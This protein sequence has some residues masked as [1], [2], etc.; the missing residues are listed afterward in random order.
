MFLAFSAACLITPQALFSDAAL[1]QAIDAR[2]MEADRLLKQGNEQLT[3]NQPEAALPTLQAALKLYRDLKDRAAEEQTLKSVGNAYQAL[4]QYEQAISHQQQALEIA[5]EIKDRNL[6]ARALH[7]IGLAYEGLKESA[8]AIEYYGQSLTVSQSSQNVEMEN[9]TLVNLGFLYKSLRDFPKANDYFKRRLELAEKAQ[10]STDRADSLYYICG[11]YL[12][13]GDF[14]NSIQTCQQA[15]T[16]YRDLKNQRREKFVLSLLGISYQSLGKHEEAISYFQKWLLISEE[17]SDLPGQAQALIAK[18]GA[19]NLIGEYGK[20]TDSG[21]QGLVIAKK[22]NRPDLEKFGLGFLFS[23]SYSLGE[24]P[25]AIEYAKQ[26]LEI[27][28]QTNDFSGQVDMIE[29]LVLLYGAFKDSNKLIEYSQSLEILTKKVDFPE[30]QAS[31]L[32]VLGEIYNFLADIKLGN[33]LYEVN[34]AMLTRQPVKSELN[35]HS[36]AAYYKTYSS[37]EIKQA[38]EYLNQSLAIVKK[39]IHDVPSG[40]PP[41]SLK[42]EEVF[43]L[44]ELRKSYS[45]LQDPKAISYGKQSLQLVQQDSRLRAFEATALAQIGIAYSRNLDSAHAIQFFQQSLIVARRDK[46]T[47]EEGKALQVLGDALQSSGDLTQAEKVLFEAVRVSESLRT[48]L[49][50]KDDLKVSLFEGQQQVYRTL[51]EVLVAQNKPAAALEVSERGRARIFIE[52]LRKRQIE[53]PAVNGVSFPSIQEIKQTAQQHKATLVVYSIGIDPLPEIFKNQS[54]NLFVWI[55]QPTGKIDFH[56]VDLSL[57][58]SSLIA[59]INLTRQAIGARGRRATLTVKSSPDA[60]RISRNQQTQQLRQLHQLLIEPIADLLPKDPTDRVIFIPQGELF[61]VPFPA[62]QDNTGKSLIDQHTLLTAPSIQVLDLTRQQRDRQK[63]HTT[64]H[65]AL[66]V[67]NPTMPKIRTQVGGDLEQLA[68]LAGAEQEAQDIAKLFNTTAITGA[69]AKKSA[70]VPQLSSAR[71]I[72]L[73]THGLLDDFK[74]LGVPGAIALGP[75]GTGKDNDGLLT[76]DEILDLKLNAELVVLSACDTGRGRI[77]G[78]GVIGLSRS[79]IT[80]GV[81]SII[82]SLWK[83]PDASTAFLMTQFYQNLQQ[84]PDKAQALRQAMLTTKQKYPDPLDWA[85]FTLIGEAE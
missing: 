67:G 12:E 61:L 16:L 81:P 32:L 28:K 60:E 4:K 10:S 82:V 31:A 24:Y 39:I 17:T 15:L 33:A 8:K 65:T 14:E 74:G 70:I 37:T 46:K 3:A 54:R 38:I 73:A 6:E 45:Y 34:Q 5:R 53:Q 20:A 42:R 79:L 23:L 62:L 43:I 47:D 85:A 68:N 19:Y 26:Y 77:T 51:E 52:Q 40:E 7:N 22:I 49:E 1:A 44:G 75:D 50:S 9:K 11:N 69:N 35:S 66:V 59:L 83:V 25:G 36:L 13:Q 76:A 72:H 71:I 80:A 18:G 63:T 27:A 30:T 55:V 48:N 57:Q 41:Q 2:K 56:T 21:K 29:S 58:Q 84:T 78:D 64:A